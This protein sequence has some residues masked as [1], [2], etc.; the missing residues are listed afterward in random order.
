MDSF[1][2]DIN[3]Q[4]CM[5]T[6]EKN[7]LRLIR[8]ARLQF[9]ETIKKALDKCEKSVTLTFDDKLWSVHRITIT[10]EL[11][12]RFGE[13]TMSSNDKKFELTKLT[14]NPGDILTSIKTIKIDF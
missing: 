11:L 4:T 14:N 9:T 13:F 8:E 6:L 2:E 5:E 7:Q 12:G 3:R 10:T 1:P